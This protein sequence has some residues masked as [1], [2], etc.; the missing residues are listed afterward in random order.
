TL[1]GFPATA[2]PGGTSFVTTL[3]APTV[4]PRPILTPGR[5]VTFP[6]SQQS[7]S[8]VMG[9]PYSGPRSPS[10]AFALSGC[11]AAKRQTLGPRRVRAPM[12]TLHVSSI[13]QPKFMNTPGDMVVL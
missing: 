8:I 2:H 10:R 3:P 6:A 7:S 4:L 12:V 9:A 1:A 5:I 13:I 11:A